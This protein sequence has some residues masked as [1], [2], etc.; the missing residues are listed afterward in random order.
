MSIIRASEIGTYLYCRRAWKYRKD[1]V[2]SS[3]QSEMAAGTALHE[4]HGRTVF[5]AL[6]WR[7]IGMALLL[8][9]L[10]LLTAYFAFQL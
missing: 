3:N 6:I 8:A 4:R 7:G 2:A 5:A 10:L 1:G 9:A